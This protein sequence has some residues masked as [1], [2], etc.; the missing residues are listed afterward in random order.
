MKSWRVEKLQRRKRV[1]KYR[2]TSHLQTKRIGVDETVVKIKRR[3]S[4]LVF[5]PSKGWEKTA[6]GHRQYTLWRQTSGDFF[7]VSF[8]P[9]RRRK[10][11][12]RKSTLVY[13]LGLS[14]PL[15]SFHH[16]SRHAKLSVHYSS[17]PLHCFL[18][19]ACKA[20][21]SLL[22]CPLHHATGM[23][24]LIREWPVGTIMRW[25]KKMEESLATRNPL[26]CVNWA[27][28]PVIMSL[29]FF[30]LPDNCRTPRTSPLC[31]MYACG[32]QAKLSLFHHR[33]PGKGGL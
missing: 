10:I 13:K 33:F 3:L 31:P 32:V 4:F 26:L 30:T 16:P 24:P 25:K 11:V 18:I 17:T 20:W 12:T 21:G 6:A 23:Q 2:T 22:E 5:G 29:F 27:A 8:N 7:L 9:C 19:A 14:V 15:F 28:Y 1:V